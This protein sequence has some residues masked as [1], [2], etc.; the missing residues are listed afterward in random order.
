MV[1]MWSSYIHTVAL[2]HEYIAPKPKV[3][4]F[5]RNQLV[6][7]KE[8]GEISTAICRKRDGRE[9]PGSIYSY[10]LS[11]SGFDF[12]SKNPDLQVVL[13]SKVLNK[14]L[15][16]LMLGHRIKIFHLW[17]YSEAHWVRNVL[18]DFCRTWSKMMSPEPDLTNLWWDRFY[19][20]ISLHQ[21]W[22]T[23]R[24][25][26]DEDF[27]SIFKSWEE[28]S[29]HLQASMDAFEEKTLLVNNPDGDDRVLSEAVAI[30][31]LEWFQVG[32]IH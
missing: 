11:C 8:D 6:Q 5:V 4:G 14:S 15:F 17:N 21:R 26:E 31:A 12:D 16:D 1:L 32:F 18:D 29:N 9:D 13:G 7:D 22:L 2:L 24:L 10:W 25:R 20:H 27:P 23:T 19:L 30:K 3:A 28:D